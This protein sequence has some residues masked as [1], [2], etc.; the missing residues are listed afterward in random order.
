LLGWR[1]AAWNWW[2]RIQQRTVL[3]KLP[4]TA[5]HIREI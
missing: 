1:E 4:A 3:T 2:S 5:C